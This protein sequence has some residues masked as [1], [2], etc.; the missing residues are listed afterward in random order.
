MLC[1]IAAGGF[2]H[3]PEPFLIMM[4]RHEC[5]SVLS[6]YVTDEVV[7]A[8]YSAAHEWLALND[9]PLN[10]YSWGA[11]G[12]ASSHGLGLALGFPK[13]R[14]LVFDGD[15]S[16]L[17]NLGSLVTIAAAAP[18]NLIHFVVQN[19]C[20]EANGGHPLPHSD[21]DFVGFA[22]A[23][24]IRACH[25]FSDLSVFKAQLPQLLRAEGPVFVALKIEHTALAA[26]EYAEMPHQ[27]TE[28]FKPA[29]RAALRAAL[30][31]MQ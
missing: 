10:H 20:Y 7:V 12:L 23:A 5:F 14:V 16:L 4:N 9:R 2:A 17:M 25:S 6:Q 3:W 24:G 19:N 31:A 28:M 29:R 21:I 11:M 13:R 22:Q 30:H 8:C 27:Y 15:G 1:A 18:R 26:D